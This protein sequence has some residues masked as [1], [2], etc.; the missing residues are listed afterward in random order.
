MR[1]ETG[2]PG[3]PHLLDEHARPDD[4]LPFVRRPQG[5]ER[6]AGL[7]AG[8]EIPPRTVS[9]PNDPGAG[10]EFDLFNPLEHEAPLQKRFGQNSDRNPPVLQKR[11]KPGLR[12]G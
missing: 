10:I 12:R 3:A 1:Q 2:G 7:T 9:A 11:P 6:L 4:R 5:L 8:F